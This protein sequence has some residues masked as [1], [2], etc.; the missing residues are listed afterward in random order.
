MPVTHEGVGWK[1]TDTSH[2]AAEAAA[3]AAPILRTRV[4]EVMRRTSRALTADEIAARIDVHFL[5]VRP[6]VAELHAAGRLVD[7]GERRI[8]RFGR[9]QIAWR[10]PK[11]AT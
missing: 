9:P 5:S 6:R 3:P 7:S 4:M 1:G 10:T 11:E 8:G 2:A